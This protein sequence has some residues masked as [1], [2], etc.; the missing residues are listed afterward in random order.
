M[1]TLER[2]PQDLGEGFDQEGFGETR[3][4]D[5]Q[6]VAASE[7]AGQQQAHDLVLADDDLAQ[8]G[9]NFLIDLLDLG[10][11]QL[12]HR[13]K[14]VYVAFTAREPKCGQA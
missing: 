2:E 3:H 8:F 6:A 5:Q 13:A 7:E 10:G 12:V 11:R 9:A 1:H 4:A 14:G